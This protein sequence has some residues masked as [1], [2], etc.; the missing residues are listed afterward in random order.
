MRNVEHLDCRHE[1]LAYVLSASYSGQAI[2]M[3]TGGILERTLGP[4]MSSYIGGGILASAV[5]AS[6]FLLHSY[7]GFIFTYGGL[8]GLGTFQLDTSRE[9]AEI[10]RY[11]G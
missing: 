6:S 5:F 7:V 4:R 8:F 3:V 9:I 11:P 10:V 2:G 1:D